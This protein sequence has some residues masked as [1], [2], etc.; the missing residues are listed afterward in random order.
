LPEERITDSPVPTGGGSIATGVERVGVGGGLTSLIAQ[1]GLAHHSQPWYG[2]AVIQRRETIFRRLLGVSDALALSL[3]IAIGA[4]LFGGDTVA[5]GAIAAPLLLILI[6]KAMGLYD[7]DAHLLHKT[8]LDEV[9]RLLGLSTGAVLLI[10][11]ADGL[12]V[13]GEFDRPQAVVTWAVL[14]TGLIGLRALAR[15]LA[16]RST[17]IERCLFVGDERSAEEFREKLATSHAVRAELVGWLPTSAEPTPEEEALLPDRVRN[18]IAQRDVHR[19]VLGP[20][21]GTRESLLDA[22]RRIQGHQ[23]RVSVLPDVSRVVNSS[24]ELDRLNGITL[25][26]LRRFD[27][28]LSSRLIKRSFDIAGSALGLTLTAPLLAVTAIAIKLDTPGP[29]LFRQRRAGR[30]G[31]PFEMLKFRSMV[32]GAD[33]Q[34]EALRHLNEADGVFKIADDPRI[35][36]VGKVI[37]ALHIDELPQLVN[38]LRGEMSLVGP[39]PLPLDED[40]RIQGWH[41]RRLDLRPGITGP[42]QVLGS[43][44]IPVR[45]MVKLDYQYVAHWSLWND[46]RILLLTVGHVA[47]RRGQ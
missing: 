21:P 29:V 40:R 31:E 38:V 35:T 1:P 34:K 19:V 32:D 8:T 26:G 9:P 10:W 24:V 39:R 20:G 45:E 7:R 23:V 36:R 4:L 15:F 46:I 5:P 18:L 12:V 42:W 47:R 44:R 37:R 33:E 22:I 25:L 43:A 6:A 27:M 3:A 28:T 14:F 41:R 30:H 2:G 17:P 16:L 11:L 13:A